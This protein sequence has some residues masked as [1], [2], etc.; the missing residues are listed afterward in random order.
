MELITDLLNEDDDNVEL[1]YFRSSIRLKFSFPHNDK[2]LLS[3][4][5]FTCLLHYPQVHHGSGCIRLCPAGYGRGAISLRA[6]Q[7]N[8]GKYLP[9]ITRSWRGLLLHTT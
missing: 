7:R 1:W 6:R 3:I 5:S 2:N 8:A 9:R 4:I